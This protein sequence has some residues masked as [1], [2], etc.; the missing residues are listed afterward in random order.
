[1]DLR[2]ATLLSVAVLQAS[3]CTTRYVIPTGELVHLDGYDV[4]HEQQLAH[5]IVTDRAFRVLAPDGT[6]TDFNSRVLLRLD[7][8]GDVPGR[9]HA[10]DTISVDGDVHGRS[11]GNVG[12]SHGGPENG[13]S[14]G[15]RA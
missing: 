11:E 5:S 6:P 1:M 14:C 7:G 12:T 3:G 8:A 13:E 2:A 15:G 10:Y 9:F 4:H